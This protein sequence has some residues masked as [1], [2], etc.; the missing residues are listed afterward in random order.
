M[1]P[2]AHSAPNARGLPGFGHVLA[3]IADMDEAPLRTSG[4]GQPNVSPGAG[5]LMSA[6]QGAPAIAPIQS[7]SPAPNGGR[8]AYPQSRGIGRGQL[9]AGILADTFAGAMGRPGTF[10]PMMERRREQDAERRVQWGRAAMEH[11]IAD[12]RLRQPQFTNVEG[13]G[14]VA[15]DPVN[16]TSRVIQPSRSPGQVYAESLGYEPGTPEYNS[17]MADVVLN[18]NGPTAFGQRQTLQDDEQA[19]ALAR[20][21]QS[22]A[23]Q[24]SL[25][26]LRDGTTRRGQDVQADTSRENNIRSTSQ[27]NTNNQRSTSQSNTNNQRSTSQSN[28]NSMRSAAGR[29]RGRGGAAPRARNAQGQV[30]EFRGGQWVRVQ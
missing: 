16:L 22:L 4:G 11:D 19:A 8:P 25:G 28:T 2:F 20:L 15:V 14:H 26:Y 3:N 18:S 27:S 5:A 1:M 6:L 17:A 29:G 13:V 21:E 10:A 23:L 12:R 9:I 30:M 7:P 24:R